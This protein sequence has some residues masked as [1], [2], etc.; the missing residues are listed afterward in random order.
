MQDRPTPEE[1]LEAV[2]AFLRD[3]V[4]PGAASGPVAFHARVAANVLDIA[5][6]QLALAPAAHERER[7]ALMKLLGADPGNDLA[8]LNRMLC[9][10]IAHGAMDLDTPGLDACLWQI[11]LD[12][13]A[14]D[15]PNYEAYVRC[16][17]DAEPDPKDR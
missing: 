3:R 13:L 1:L 8:Q 17:R 14:V 10:R 12:K 4:V 5:R 7:A 9:E 15:Q 6:R 11:T 16:L 2:A